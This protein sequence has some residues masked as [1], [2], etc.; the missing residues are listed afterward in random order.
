MDHLKE[1]IGLRSYGQKDPL[2]E[3]K[4][5]SYVL[6]ENMKNNIKHNSVETI[7]KIRLYTQ[8]EIDE[9][10]RQ[11]QAMLEAQLET[12]RRAEEAKNNEAQ[13][14]RNTQARVAT[15]SQARVGRNDACPMWVWEKI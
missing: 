9:I 11:Q 12:H 7:F 5:D 13:R 15:R 14:E 3:Y 8:A 2:V 1:G 10:K 6:F 4:R